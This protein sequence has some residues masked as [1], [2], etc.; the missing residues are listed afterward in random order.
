MVANI[1]R[2]LRNSVKSAS[3]PFPHPHWLILNRIH[4]HGNSFYP[5]KPSFDP[6]FLNNYSHFSAAVESKI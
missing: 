2:M 3:E 5:R 1:A 6:A 4:K